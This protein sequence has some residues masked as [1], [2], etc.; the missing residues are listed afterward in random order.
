MNVSNR[1]GFTLIELLIV[2]IIL[3]VLAA[4]VV[5][6]FSTSTNDA[7]EAALKSTLAEMRNAIELYYHQHNGKYPG[8]TLLTSGTGVTSD[9]DDFRD[10][11]VLYTNINGKGQ[12]TQDLGATPPIKYGP[13]L[14]SAA[15]PI[16][17]IDDSRVV[18]LV[19]YS[20]GGDLNDPAAAVGTSGGWWFD[21]RTGKFV[22]NTAGQATDGTNYIDW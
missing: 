5:P 18:E 20:T 8:H 12:S 21:A 4:I 13:Y 22:A 6:Q 9:P 17:P 10:Q 16:N 15:L 3:A 7:K 19:D 11:L 1:S 2:V 14:K